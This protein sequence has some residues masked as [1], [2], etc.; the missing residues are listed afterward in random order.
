MSCGDGALPPN[1]GSHAGA[2]HGGPWKVG[3]AAGSPLVSPP[4]G[5][6]ASRLPC[7]APP[8][9]SEPALS[10]RIPKAWEH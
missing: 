2:V 6:G 3:C 4:G 9:P 5:A 10:P 1:R 7:S 8:E